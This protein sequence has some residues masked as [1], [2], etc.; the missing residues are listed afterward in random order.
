MKKNDIF[1]GA[2]CAMLLLPSGA[3]ALSIVTLDSKAPL[4]EIKVM[5][6]AGSAQDPEGLEGI[7]ALTGRL[8]IEGGYGDPA[9]PVTKERLA[10]IARPWGSG[11]YPG[12]SVSK[13]A[14]VFSFKVPREAL[15]EYVEQVLAPLLTRPLF[16]AKELERVRGEILQALRSSL[17]LEEIENLGLVGLD[18]YV[19]EGTAYAHPDMG[20]EKGLQTVDRY[21]LL[22]FYRTYYRPENVVV[23]LSSADKSLKAR[24]EGALSRIGEV[25][26]GAFSS[27]ELKAPPPIQGRKVLIVGLPN[28]ISSGLHVGFSIPLTRKDPD[29]WPLYVAN[30]WFGAHR[31]GFSHLYQVIREERG[32]NY[33]DYSYIEHFEGRPQHLFPPFN[34]PRRS[35]YFSVWVR[36]V[37]HDYI[38]HILKAVAWEL[39]DFV[40]AGLAEEQCA[41]AK[42]KAKV[43]YLSLAETA[44]RLLAG[45]L[46]DEFYGMNPGYLPGYLSRIEGVQCG[47]VNAAIRK[48]LQAK[49]LKVLVVTHAAQASKI[50]QEIASGEA[51]WGKSPADYQIDVKEED[52]RKLYLVPEPKLEILRRDAL[53]AHAPLGIGKDDIRVVPAEKM[54]ETSALPK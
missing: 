43:L 36:P 16:N 24:L 9:H 14:T 33:G 5:V 31:D 49:D 28:A 50:A 1:F 3:K 37:A 35:Q 2:L 47:E 42:N 27:R 34:T 8:L 40:R 54:F 15:G 12:V 10:E 51:L 45:R 22:R 18:N 23:G 19:H 25:E 30:V 11:A 38:P 53:W 21:G 20:T 7:A 17:R 4:V 26:A 52:G 32:Y 44:E 39:E 48:Y 29:F 41:L 13:E 46:D 6:K